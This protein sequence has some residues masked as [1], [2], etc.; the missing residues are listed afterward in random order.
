ME[1]INDV[2]LWNDAIPGGRLTVFLIAVVFISIM[3]VVVYFVERHLEGS[4][5]VKQWQGQKKQ[6]PA[7]Y[8]VIREWQD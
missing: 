4:G 2:G 8:E 3:A 6:Q 1:I 7:S 5:I